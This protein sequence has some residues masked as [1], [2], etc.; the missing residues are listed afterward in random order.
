MATWSTGEL[1]GIDRAYQIEITSLRRDG[2]LRS[3]RIIWGVCVDGDYYV[4]SVNGPT[5]AW[6]RGTRTRHE[7]RILADG[8][9]K[10]VSFVDIDDDALNDRIDEAYALKYGR[11]TEPVRR[12]TSAAARATTMRVVPR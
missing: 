8:A 5:A 11:G 7:G 3:F 12:I 2:S 9:E 1:A 4:R 6:Y 10:D